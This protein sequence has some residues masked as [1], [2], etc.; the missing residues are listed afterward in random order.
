MNEL[1]F[2]IEGFN[3]TKALPYPFTVEI[4]KPLVYDE[5]VDGYMISSIG[6]I[7]STFYKKIMKPHLDKNGY[8]R[9]SLSTGCGECKGFGIHRLVAYNFGAPPDN[10]KDLV[11]NHIVPDKLLN[12]DTNLEWVTAL[13]NTRHANA[14]VGNPMNNPRMMDIDQAKKAIDLMMQG[15]MDV[16]ILKMLNIPKTAST[17]STLENIRKKVSYKELTVG[18]VI[19]NS[20]KKGITHN[21]MMTVID[22]VIDEDPLSVIYQKLYGKELQPGE[23]AEFKMT[24]KKLSL[25]AHFQ[26]RLKHRLGWKVVKDRARYICSMLE[27]G[28]AEKDISKGLIQNKWV[29]SDT[30]PRYIHNMITR[31]KNKVVFPE[32]TKDYNY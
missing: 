28:K 21:Q 20:K 14:T 3:Y 18:L 22:C 23:V 13:E 30:E 12:W 32:I 6:R 4:W 9:I 25:S 8:S 10:Y 5:V 7:Y 17:I 24:L 15:Y 19:P 1:P 27:A 16:H 29:E 2:T 11:V 31:L 26:Q